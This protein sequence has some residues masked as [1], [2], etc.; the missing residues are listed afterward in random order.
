MD[1]HTSLGQLEELA[2]KLGIQVRY[3]KIVDELTGT[4]GLC[5]IEGKYVLMIR[6]NT[7]VK[8]K[9]RVMT[10]A[11][12]RFDLADIYVRPAIRELLERVEE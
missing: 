3:E 12:R 8:E 5:R 6:S 11:L 7:S 4:G 9:I 2:D 10:Q 1:D